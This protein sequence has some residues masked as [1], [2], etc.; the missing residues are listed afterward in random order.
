MAQVSPRQNRLF[1]SYKEA[2][3]GTADTNAFLEGLGLA[4]ALPE[5]TWMHESDKTKM[6]AG[7]HGTKT[8]LQAVYT[9][10]SYSPQ[11]LGEIAYM[12]SYFQGAADYVPWYGASPGQGAYLHQ[13][14]H[15][16]VSTRTM[17]TFT[18]EHGDASTNNKIVGNVVNDFS[19]S[20]SQ[21][22]NG[23]VDATFN[24]FGNRHYYSGGAITANA[25][26]TMSSEDNNIATDPLLNFK[27]L[28]FW[29]ADA[30]SIGGITSLSLSGE[31]L[32]ANLVTLSPLLNSITI[33]GNNGMS[34][35]DQLRANGGG[36]INHWDRKDRTY[37][38]E[39][40][41]R[42]DTSTINLDTLLVA[43]TQFA[44]ELGYRG[45]NIATGYPYAI[46]FFW[47]KVQVTAGPEDTE[48]PQAKAV[49]FEVF[50][51]TNNTACI[52]Y[53]QSGVSVGY[54]SAK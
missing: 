46:N 39:A 25:T 9:P 34:G 38:I 29:K 24:G 42:K 20:F 27:S 40:T 1:F 6:G 28:D 44:L 54:N 19:I 12:L 37:T 30:T 3:A 47:P 48:T 21:G 53:V 23:V 22:G 43:D 8:E 31:D 4:M 45:P 51:D 17:P 49:S 10:W 15:L 35:E 11:R 33:T 14:N 7:E 41:L 36:V 13:M 32:G 50:E 18:I 5:P 2:T 16:P 52:I 26:G